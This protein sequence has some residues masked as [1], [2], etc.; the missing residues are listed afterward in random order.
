MN[1]SMNTQFAKNLKKKCPKPNK[2]D[3]AGEFLD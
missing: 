3:N 1:P 2:D